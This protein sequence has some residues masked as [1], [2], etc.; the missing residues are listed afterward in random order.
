MITRGLRNVR[1]HDRVTAD[2]VQVDYAFQKLDDLP[3][4]FTLPEGRTKPWGTGQ[5]VRA[6][7]GGI[8]VSD[9]FIVNLCP[10]GMVPTKA[11][12]THVPLSPVEVAADEA[13]QKQGLMFRTELAPD[14]GMLFDFHKAGPL[15]FWMKNTPLSLDILFI[16][17]DGT[18]STIASDTIPY[19]EDAIPSSEPVRAVLEIGG[20][21]SAAL[22]IRPGAK[23][24]TAIFGNGP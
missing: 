17:D 23:V 24:H 5:A 16:R 7:R 10:T 21:R 12:S 2:R 9:E 20:G 14:A 11:V 8:G 6:A 13:S 4:G 1:I 18:I 15:A 19:S 3:D 22:G